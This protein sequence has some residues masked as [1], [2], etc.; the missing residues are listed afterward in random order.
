MGFLTVLLTILKIIGIVLACVVGLLLLL[1]SLVL[2]SPIGYKGRIRYDGKPDIRLKARY[3]FGVVRAYFIMDENGR[4]MDAKILWRSVLKRK[5]PKRRRAAGRGRKGPVGGPERFDYET[6]AQKT[7]D[8]AENAAAPPDADGKGRSADGSEVLRPQSRQPERSEPLRQPPEQPQPAGNEDGASRKKRKK[9]SKQKKSIFKR[10][11]DIYNKIVG[12]IRSVLDL[13]DRLF[14]EINDE[15]NR[16][17]VRFLLGIL[18]KLFRHMLPRKHRIYIRFGTGDPAATGQILGAAYAFGALLGLN[19]A[20]EPDFEKKVLECDIP[21]R[22]HICLFRALVWAVQV[23][24]NKN[25]RALLDKV[26]A[27]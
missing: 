18:R 8:R 6:A 10:I 12:Q 19:L 13:R 22:G 15:S 20:V 14:R 16:G 27:R 23:Y 2:F 25:V 9:A 26:T 3:L 4:Q 24:R 7:P 1:I 21:F 17:A 5:P 11:K